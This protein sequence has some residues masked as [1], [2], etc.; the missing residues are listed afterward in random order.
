MTTEVQVGELKRAIE[1]QHGCTATFIQSVSVKE[2]IG[3]RDIRGQDRV[4]W[5][6]ARFQNQWASSG[7]QSLCLVIS[8]CGK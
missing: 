4:G 8:D 6:R 5:H 2:T 1:A 3:Q 7:Q